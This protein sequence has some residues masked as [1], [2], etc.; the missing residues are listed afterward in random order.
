MDAGYV[1][2]VKTLDLINRLEVLQKKKKGIK[3]NTKAVGLRVERITLSSTE[4][5]NAN[6]GAVSRDE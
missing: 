5:G 6:G 4:V 3:N 2:K 1:L